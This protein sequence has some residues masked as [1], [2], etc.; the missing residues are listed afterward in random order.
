LRTPKAP[1]RCPT[2]GADLRRRRNIQAALRWQKK[3]RE[4]YN[5]YMRR[6]MAKYSARKREKPALAG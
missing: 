5:E 1:R 2:C 6:Y 4:H 3:N